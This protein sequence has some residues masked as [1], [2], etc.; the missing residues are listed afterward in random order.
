MAVEA[1]AK[2]AGVSP[3]KATDWDSVLG[4]KG[5]KGKD[6][7]V[8]R[9]T[10][11]R[12]A[13]PWDIKRRRQIGNRDATERDVSPALVER[14]QLK[15]AVTKPAT[16]ALDLLGL[17]SVAA[18]KGAEWAAVNTDAPTSVIAGLAAVG[19]QT[20]YVLPI[21]KAGRVLQAGGRIIRAI[22]G[23]KYAGKAF[24]AVRGEGGGL[25]EETIARERMAGKEAAQS[26]PPVAEKLKPVVA[27]S[28][29][30]E[31]LVLAPKATPKGSE[32]VSVPAE[33][34]ITNRGSIGTSEVNP[35]AVPENAAKP[36]IMGEKSAVVSPEVQGHIDKLDRA[37]QAARTKAEQHL[38]DAEN[39][40]EDQAVVDDEA[41]SASV[42]AK[43]KGSLSHGRNIP[44]TARVG[45]GRIW[46]N[47]EGADYAE[48][49][50]Y[51]AHATPE[52]QNY[53]NSILTTN[54]AT[55]RGNHIENFA[56]E[57]GFDRVEDMFNAVGEEFAGG[58]GKGL[59]IESMAAKYRPIKNALEEAKQWETHAN[60]L[61]ATREYIAGRGGAVKDDS[62]LGN[63]GA[64]E[65]DVAGG[66]PA[67]YRSEVLGGE[68]PPAEA[69][70]ARAAH[71]EADLSKARTGQPIQFDGYRGAGKTAE[72][73]Y[74]GAQVPVVGKGTYVAA[75]EQDAAL[76][77]SNIIRVPVKLNN[78]LV[79]RTDEEWR[80]LTQSAGWR[81][82]NPVT[83]AKTGEVDAQ[84]AQT[85]ESLK[86]EVL[87]RGHDGLV[88]DPSVRGDEAKT[89]YRV[90]DHPQVVDYTPR[91][92]IPAEPLKVAPEPPMAPETPV[93]EG[94]PADFPTLTPE[95]RTRVREYAG[96]REAISTTDPAL[97]S[98]Q[99][100]EEQDAIRSAMV[101]EAIASRKTPKPPILYD[102][103]L[104]AGRP[105]EK[106]AR[107]LKELE[108][109]LAYPDNIK[110]PEVDISPR[111]RMKSTG[112]GAW[113][114]AKQKGEE[115]AVKKTEYYKNLRESLIKKTG[116]MPN[117]DEARLAGRIISGKATIKEVEE[118]SPA[119]RE[120]AAGYKKI[121]DDLFKYDGLPA[122]KYRSEYLMRM[123]KERAGNKWSDTINELARENGIRL[124]P[125]WKE[126]VLENPQME[127][128]EDPDTLLRMQVA[129]SVKYNETA[130]IVSALKE[131]KDYIKAIRDG[132]GTLANKLQLAGDEGWRE[133]QKQGDKYNSIFKMLDHQ[134]NREVGVSE[135]WVEA[136]GEG[137]KAGAPMMK[138]A[139][140]KLRKLPLPK[141]AREYLDASIEGLDN[142]AAGVTKP[143][144]AGKNLLGGIR[145]RA[146]VARFGGILANPV[147]LVHHAAARTA[148]ALN[149][150]GT[151]S[152]SSGISRAFA[153]FREGSLESFE[154]ANTG[155]RTWVNA[156]KQFEMGDKKGFIR[157]WSTEG[158]RMADELLARVELFGAKDAAARKGLVGKEAEDYVRDLMNFM[159]PNYNKSANM[160]QSELAKQVMQGAQ[161][162]TRASGHMV[163]GAITTGRAIRAG[164]GKEGWDV[165][166]SMMEAD[167][168]ATAFVRLM[169]T[170]GVMGGA[171]AA[172]G[173]FLPDP[174]QAVIFP[175][176]W[177]KKGDLKIGWNIGALGSAVA[178]GLIPDWRDIT[179]SR[180]L[181]KT[182]MGVGMKTGLNLVGLPIKGVANTMDLMGGLLERPADRPPLR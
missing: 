142:L 166:R 117:T 46:L 72:E 162:S 30:Q 112:L 172:V 108:N 152:F 86:A 76:Y 53:W 176:Y 163:R 173:K 77:G 130:H 99:K 19:E 21:P 85:S 115:A 6:V 178:P 180:N 132:Y 90:F 54:K 62:L 8:P 168:R 171:Q 137:L 70:S 71:V 101:S 28:P 2:D 100:V 155:Y 41:Y 158:F 182:A 82:A 135:P 10:G 109:V 45:P 44:G 65:A 167:P 94:K 159:I 81:N 68:T 22:P 75:T 147:S 119:V 91:K 32:P 36:T 74:T 143:E 121:T 52:E 79:I 104:D 148:M 161:Q 40:A 107:E 170:V 116:V 59:D 9:Q 33:P 144:A 179:R 127:L 14:E 160:F 26:A 120:Y 98:A 113:N 96:V 63:A 138:G 164:I 165:A 58:V 92:V 73:I 151:K 39:M 5:G 145:A 140:E 18:E 114:N 67:E 87:R 47:P 129:M 34:V 150:L 11:M 64:P 16:V 175:L 153:S 110:A 20:A 56:R 49:K 25:L 27:T 122:E 95:E 154:W 84:M 31:E 97:A 126:R 174:I 177:D 48:V 146:A 12:E 139:L 61:K 88:I 83:F 89:L 50:N 136:V 128:I 78:P 111:E 43:I 3:L 181:P 37:E 38:T 169:T 7:E 24:K 35:V 124:P 51:L 157:K 13:T 17:P 105:A 123:A 66:V 133:A 29:V 60:E 103:K 118:A 149:Y 4:E 55:S 80:A 141:A 131:T 42:Q 1:P 134:Y 102:A 69:I 23:A 156:Q 125:N 106:V 15:Y 57:R 93:L